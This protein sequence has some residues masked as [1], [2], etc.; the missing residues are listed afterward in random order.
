SRSRV[1]EKSLGQGEL[2]RSGAGPCPDSPGKRRSGHRALT[3]VVMRLWLGVALSIAVTPALAGQSTPPA[4]DTLLPVAHYLDLE[5]VGKRQI[6]ADG[7]TIVY[8]RGWVDKINDRWENAIWIMNADGT[9]N[10]FLAKGGGPVWSPDG[11]RIAYTA[12][13]DEPKGTQI[14]V[15]WMDA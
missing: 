2:A 14:F 11:T 3:G 9:K 4:A 10:R 5:Q 8:T 7:K 1:R 13:A 15:R 12:A 6:A